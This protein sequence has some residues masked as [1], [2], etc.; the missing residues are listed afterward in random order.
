MPLSGTALFSM[1]FY[2]PKEEPLAQIKIVDI[3]GRVVDSFA[4]SLV[5][6]YNIFMHPLNGIEPGQYILILSDKD[7]SYV[8]ENFIV[9]K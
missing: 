4:E 8:A 9:G 1:Q 2:W 5:E 7:G 6:G 3:T